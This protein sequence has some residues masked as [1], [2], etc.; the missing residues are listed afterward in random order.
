MLQLT[1]DN[2]YSLEADREYLSCSQYD[3]FCE[4]EAKA[5]AKLQGR[6][7]PEETKALK[8]GKYFHAYFEGQDEFKAYCDANFYDIFKTKETKARGLEITGK[9]SDYELA[10]KM[11]EV[12]EK[13]PVIKRFIDMSGEN[14]RIMTGKLF[15]LY[16]WKIRLDK[17][18]PEERM[19][20][21]WKTV[22][23]I[24]ELQWNSYYGQKVSFVENYGYLMRAAVYCEIEKQVT[25]NTVDPAFILVCISKQ[26][27]P[28]KEI[29]ILNHRQRLDY[30][31][32][33]MRERLG[34]IQRIRN[35]DI[36]PKRCG[37]CDYCRSTKRLSG[38][39][40]Y[41]KL[42]PANRPPREDDYAIHGHHERA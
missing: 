25:D 9:Y 13:D 17:Y 3:A 40:E 22:A 38:V 37:Y 18:M 16:P 10:D 24:W 4:C 15:G 7:V 1:S 23:N 21:D 26:D 27:P 39:I 14:E 6:F 30:E 41:Y 34:R 5:F 12:A 19:V 29:I 28:D 36:L 31:L 20:L 2:Y 33:L 42:E 8:I 11:I 35:G 32:E